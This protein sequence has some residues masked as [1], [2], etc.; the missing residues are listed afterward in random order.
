MNPASKENTMS[1]PAADFVTSLPFNSLVGV[2]ADGEALALRDDGALHNHVGTVHAGALF[3][4]GEAASGI[5]IARHCAGA[6]GGAMPVT[7]TASIAYRRPARGRI[8]AIAGVAE[9]VDEIAARLARDGK[10]SFDVEVAL[11]DDA[12]TEV[13]T[14]TV[15][16]YVRA[17]A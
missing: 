9:S 6:F 17:V 5:A 2:S 10:A 14:M 16:W 1:D 4:L 8:R 7:K 3:T 12:G 13:A 15:A 11:T